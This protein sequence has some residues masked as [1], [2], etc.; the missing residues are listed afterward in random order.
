[1]VLNCYIW[2]RSLFN[3]QVWYERV[4]RV[5]NFVN[6]KSRNNNSTSQIE[7]ESA[8]PPIREVVITTAPPDQRGIPQ[9]YGN[10]SYDV[11]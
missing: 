3:H 1:M 5:L 8:V 10:I 4:V 2:I 11:P 9:V 7:E 6:N